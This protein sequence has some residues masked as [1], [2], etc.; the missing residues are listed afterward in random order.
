[1]HFPAESSTSRLSPHISAKE[2]SVRGIARKVQECDALWEDREKFLEE[3]GWREF[4]A[5]LLF[6]HPEMLVEPLKKEYAA[7]KWNSG[8]EILLAWTKGFTGF[9][10]FDKVMRALAQTGWMHN[11]VRMVASSFLVK[12]L[13]RAMR[14]AV[15]WLFFI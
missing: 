4:S 6:L 8:D 7:F 1:M 15:G 2:I 11:R 12:N 5:Y 3:L 10:F 13:K 14:K 9:P